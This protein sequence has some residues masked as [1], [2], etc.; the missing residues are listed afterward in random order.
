M[1]P[2][3]TLF[4]GYIQ[5]FLYSRRRKVCLSLSLAWWVMHPDISCSCASYFH[6]MHTFVQPPRPGP[7]ERISGHSSRPIQASYRAGLSSSSSSLLSASFTAPNLLNLSIPLPTPSSSSPSPASLTWH[8]LTPAQCWEIIID[9]TNDLKRASYLGVTPP[10]R[11]HLTPLARQ[12]PLLQVQ[13]VGAQL[14]RPHTSA[15]VLSGYQHLSRQIASRSE[16]AYYENLYPLEAL[17]K[18][19]PRSQPPPFP[20]T[21]ITQKPHQSTLCSCDATARRPIW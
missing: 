17:N 14:P 13:A 16:P 20:R 1:Q 18:M 7:L 10:E 15:P 9:D 21:I 2:F 19:C 6:P 8:V 12:P 11:A 3:Q 5:C 4:F